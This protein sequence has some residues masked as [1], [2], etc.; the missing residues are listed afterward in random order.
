MARKLKNV[1][2]AFAQNPAPMA[3]TSKKTVDAVLGLLKAGNGVVSLLS[4]LLASA[5]ILYSGYVLY[6]SFSTEGRA[7]SSSWELLQYKPEII[8]N[9]VDPSAG[10]DTLADINKDYR[11]WLTVYDSSIDYPV[12]QGQND[13]YYASHDIYQNT[14]LTGSIYLAAGNSRDFSDS[15]NLIYGHHIDNGAMFGA[16][17]KYR[18][19]SYYNSHREGIVV[20]ESGIYDLTAFAVIQT[21]AYE[22]HIYSVG[23]R[24]ADV[25][26]FLTG[27]RSRDVGIGTTI[28]TLDQAVASRA[29]K[30]VALSTCDNAATNGRLVVFF[31][32]TTRVIPTATPEPTP[33][34][35]PTPEPTDTPQPDAT[36]TPTDEPSEKPSVTPTP[37]PTPSKRPTVTQTPAP[38]NETIS[39]PVPTNTPKPG[40]FNLQ[41]RYEYLDGSQAAPTWYA[42]LM[43]GEEYSRENPVIQGFITARKVVQGVMGEQDTVIV[44]LYIPIEIADQGVTISIDEYEIPLGIDNL[45]AQ[46]GVC[47]E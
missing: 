39:T 19:A 6:D 37:T 20:T 43:P 15:Y 27:D 45:H 30:I 28:L 3:G 21:D 11:G 2:D 47:V 7:Y 9:G 17:D 31:T 35:T 25:I 42:Q 34:P 10:Q 23:N 22:N 16:L 44:V 26:S 33:T 5:L 29:T 38:T 18:D 8:E 24:A 32:M 40:P 36:D 46:M 13:L 1:A 12:V 4:G 41:I 14:S